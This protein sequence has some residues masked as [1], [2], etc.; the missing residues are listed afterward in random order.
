MIVYWPTRPMNTLGVKV[1]AI[2]PASED[3]TA[4]VDGWLDDEGKPVT[5]N[6]I[7][8]NGVAEC[9]DE[10]GRFLIHTKRA[11]ARQPSMIFG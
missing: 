10:I 9:A 5:F 3:K 11:V 1:L 6:V 7:F 4:R 8:K 2:A